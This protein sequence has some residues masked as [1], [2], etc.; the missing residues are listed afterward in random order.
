MRE[1]AALM[2]EDAVM[3]VLAR[4]FRQ[5][6]APRIC[7]DTALRRPDDAR[8]GN[9]VPDAFARDFALELGEGQEDV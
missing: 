7:A 3:R 2:R 1:A 9:L 8:G 5:A 6:D 4:I